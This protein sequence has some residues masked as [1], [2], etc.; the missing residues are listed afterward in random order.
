MLLYTQIR[1][2]LTIDSSPPIL[3]CSIISFS[4]AFAILCLSGNSEV[5]FCLPAFLPVNHQRAPSR[6]TGLRSWDICC[7][8][9][10]SG[11]HTGLLGM[12]G[13]PC[14]WLGAGGVRGALH[15]FGGCCCPREPLPARLWAM[16]QPPVGAG[17]AG[18]AGCGGGVPAGGWES[19]PCKSVPGAW[20]NSA[21]NR[22]HFSG[23][24]WQMSE[25][26]MFGRT[27]PGD[28]SHSR[29]SPRS[30]P[31]TKCS[32]CFPEPRFSPDWLL[33]EAGG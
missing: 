17:G 15:P 18:E 29:R 4:R 3:C 1:A 21:I 24:W 2:L 6:A 32:C 22:L 33:W 30:I 26:P 28:T 16:L 10:G 9:D 8:W 12:F 19:T 13:D 23:S 7:E 31:R 5:G 25:H 14:P 20:K 27:S 11:P